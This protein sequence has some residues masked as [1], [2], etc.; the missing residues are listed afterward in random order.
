MKIVYWT[1]VIVLAGVFVALSVCQP[2]ILAHNDFLK[3]FINQEVL[4]IMAVIMTISITS[5]ATI[6]IWFNELEDKH[7]KKVFGAAR[8]EINQTA[9]YFIGLFVAQLAC[10]I[11]RSLPIFAGS[12]TSLSLFNGLSLILLLGSV[13]S[14]LDIMGVIRAL[15]PSD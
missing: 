12:D 7:G 15:T 14:L 8:R 2:T 6:H 13:L 5:I 3:G 4:S 11:I 9:F 1:S 10:L